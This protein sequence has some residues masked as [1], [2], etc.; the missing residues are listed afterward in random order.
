[1][2]V[3]EINRAKS[4]THCRGTEIKAREQLPKLVLCPD[5]WITEVP[6]HV[7]PQM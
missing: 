4:E 3:F 7:F 5:Q 1:M 2:T 6:Q